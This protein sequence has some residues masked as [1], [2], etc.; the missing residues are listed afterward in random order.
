MVLARGIHIAPNGYSTKRR[1]KTKNTGFYR[2]R[3]HQPRAGIPLK[4]GLRQIRVTRV[5]CERVP[6]AGNPLKEGLRQ[7]DDV[8]LELLFRPR[9]GIPVKEGLR[10]PEPRQCKKDDAPERVFQ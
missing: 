5:H 4:E 2:F 6:R 9:A 1:I 7:R 3:K 8:G 10:L